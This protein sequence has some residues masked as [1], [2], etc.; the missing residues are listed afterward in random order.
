MNLAT[1]AAPNVT[2]PDTALTAELQLLAKASRILE[3]NGHG[4][5]IFG[6]VAMRDPQGRGFWLKRHG[7]SLGEV[8]DHRDFLLVDFDGEVLYGD[9]KRH[10][11]WPIHAEIMK[12]RPDVNFTGHT[13]PFYC[14]TYSAIET[15]L[16]LLHARRF[17]QPARF[18]ET[19][20]FILTPAQGAAVASKLG[21]GLVVFLRHHG[22]IYCGRNRLELLS[23][24]IGVEEAC[25]EALLATA[26]GLAWS[27]PDAGDRAQRMTS[28]AKMSARD[29]DLWNYYCRVL[30]RA[31][32]A[33]DI[34]L[35]QGPVR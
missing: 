31:E 2:A 8:F 29:D 18:E 15:P 5:R 34:R 24:G 1:K 12:R 33:G 20:D 16:P 25:Q 23:S 19:S 22:V 26:S 9:G 27:A 35:S 6:H 30:A 4:D 28:S 7:I 11:E 17:A 13:H 32:Q 3:I 10:N 14:T 21:D